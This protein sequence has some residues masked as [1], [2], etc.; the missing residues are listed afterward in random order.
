MWVKATADRYPVNSYLH[1]CQ[2]V[3][4]PHC[5]YCPGHDETLAHFTTICPRFRETR[6]AGHNQVRARLASLLAKC[7]DTQWQL[8]QETPMQSTGLELQ[9]VS[10]ACMVEAGR[11]PPGDHDDSICVGNLQSDLVLVSRSLKRIGLLDLCRPFDSHSELLAAARQ[12][13]LCTY[14]PL[15]AALRSYLEQAVAT[16]PNRSPMSKQLRNCCAWCKAVRPNLPA[17]F[18]MRLH[19]S[20][21]DQITIFKCFPSFAVVV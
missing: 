20:R 8:F 2:I 9:T 10:A 1:Q 15:L 11:L 14:G 4:S 12:R 5:P 16:A 6:T 17:R 7:L 21:T 3:P 13:K 18:K 19:T